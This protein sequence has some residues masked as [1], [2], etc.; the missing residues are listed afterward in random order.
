MPSRI[1]PHDRATLVNG[2]NS[3]TGR[4]APPSAGTYQISASGRRRVGASFV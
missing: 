4:S 3:A 1:T 2:S